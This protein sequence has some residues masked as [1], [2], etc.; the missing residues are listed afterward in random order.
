[1]MTSRLRFLMP[2]V[3]ELALFDG[4]WPE[5]LEVRR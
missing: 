2:L 3:G 1:M 5:Y 4:L